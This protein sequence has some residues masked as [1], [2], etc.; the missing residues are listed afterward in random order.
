MSNVNSNIIQLTIKSDIE[1]AQ[2]LALRV[3]QRR[4]EL[5]LTQLGLAQRSG[6]NIE[7]YRKFERTGEIS[8]RKLIKIAI[9][10]S[11]EADFEMLFHQR[12]YESMSDVLNANSVTRK[13]GKKK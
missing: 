9:A 1:I 2:E 8:L 3:K 12:K 10:I 7:T 13:R 6:V 4:L 5:N 11:A